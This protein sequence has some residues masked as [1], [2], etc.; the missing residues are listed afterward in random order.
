[1]ISEATRNTAGRSL[2]PFPCYL[3]YLSEKVSAGVKK[4]K[5]VRQVFILHL[6]LLGEGESK[7]FL[8][9]TKGGN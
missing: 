7:Y 2:R 4:K 8:T 6:P 1:V 3:Y 9:T 5:E